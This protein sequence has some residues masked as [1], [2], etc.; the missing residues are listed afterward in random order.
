MSG[1]FRE[2][3]PLIPDLM[4]GIAEMS[5]V[6]PVVLAQAGN[7]MSRYQ[8]EIVGPPLTWSNSPINGISPPTLLLVGELPNAV[9]PARTDR[10]DFGPAENDGP[11]AS[12]KGSSQ[13]GCACGL[14]FDETEVRS[15]R[16]DG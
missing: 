1:Y 13:H 3:E 7:I 2:L 11:L 15:G 9:R 14:A 12:S 10:H 16:A 5:K 4:V 8:Y 6:D